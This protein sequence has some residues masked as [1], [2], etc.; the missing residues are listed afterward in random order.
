M[1][2]SEKIIQ[3]A[4]T[5]PSGQELRV[6]VHD[7]NAARKL[8][9]LLSALLRSLNPSG[10]RRPVFLGIGTD[11]STG[12]SLGPLVGARLN[13]LA[14]G[15][16]PVYGTLEQPVHAVNLREKIQEIEKNYPHPL[17][18]A[19]DACLGQ[20]QN[21]GSINMGPGAL[22]PGAGVHKMLPP[23]GDIF[24]S[25]VVNI[26]GYMEYLVLQNTRLSQVIK[27]ADCITRAIISGYL[28]LKEE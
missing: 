26:G 18:I 7:A 5:P 11:R 3:T 24:F 22:Q 21:V 2:F 15:L 10:N 16:L 14:P 9:D 17:I 27:M 13:E 20:L 4:P 28:P 8:A 6:F 25:G 23:V 19:V 1:L 12:D